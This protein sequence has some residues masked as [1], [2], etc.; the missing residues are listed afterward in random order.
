MAENSRKLA[1]L[2]SKM[3][4]WF[5]RLY[6]GRCRGLYSV[7]LSGEEHGGCITHSKVKAIFPIF[8]SAATCRRLPSR[9]MSRREKRGRTRVVHGRPMSN[10]CG[11]DG[12]MKRLVSVVGWG[13]A[14]LASVALS[15][16]EMNG[17]LLFFAIPHSAFCTCTV[18]VVPLREGWGIFLRAAVAKFWAKS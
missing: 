8:W 13:L 1:S 17:W 7:S 15:A 14:L 9:D 3:S 5:L 16:R 10:P 4:D 18:K 12:R 6:P 11:D 2:R